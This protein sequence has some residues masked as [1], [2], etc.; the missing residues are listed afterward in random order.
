M[1][2]KTKKKKLKNKID[3]ID[4]NNNAQDS[5]DINK[6]KKKFLKTIDKKEESLI[7]NNNDMKIQNCLKKIKFL[8]HLKLK[9]RYNCT[10]SKYDSYILDY[11]LN[12]LDCHIVSIFKEKM[13]TDYIEEFLRR[14]YNYVECSQRIPK[15]SVYYKNYLNFFCKPIYNSFKFNKIIQNYGEKKAELYYKQNYQGG[16]TNEEGDNG[17]EQSSDDESSN[18]E[19]EYQSKDDGN[20][21]NQQIKEKLD[22]VTVMTTISTG[23]NNTI[24][25]NINNEKIE[26]FSEN[27]ADISNDTTVGE[28]MNDI[29]KEIIKLQ[30]K[31]PKSIKK[32]YKYSY[33]N[34]MNFSLKHQDKSKDNKYRKNLSIENR[35]R[36]NSK[37][38]SKKLLLNKE[39]KDNINKNKIRSNNEK[40]KSQK[41]KSKIIKY[42]IESYKINTNRLKKISRE[43]IEKILKN[44]Y[45][46]NSFNSLYNI[47][48]PYYNFSKDSVSNVRNISSNIKSTENRKSKKAIF[49]GYSEKKI[50]FKSRNHLNSLFKSGI[51][52]MNTTTGQNSNLNLLTTR[53]NKINLTELI[54]S[55]TKTFKTMKLVKTAVHQNTNN[56][57][58][59]KQQF[60]KNKSKISPNNKKMYMPENKMSSMKSLD[61]DLETQHKYIS[62]NNIQ[63]KDKFKKNKNISINLNNNL[64]KINNK[65]K[66]VN[67]NDNKNFNHKITV[68]TN[69]YLNTLKNKTSKV[70]NLSKKRIF[71]SSK[72]IFSIN[73]QKYSYV[74]NNVNPHQLLYNNEECQTFRKNMDYNY[75][76]TSKNNNNIMQIALALLIDNNSP[77][78][79]NIITNSIFNNTSLNNN[80]KII[81]K[82]NIINQK[83]SQN[84]YFNINSPT[85]YNININNQ[86]NI[87]INDKINGK[88][89]NN[90]K[91]K[92][93]KNKLKKNINI[94]TSERERKNN[95]PKKKINQK[96]NTIINNKLTNLYTS[97]NN[98]TNNQIKTRNNND[99]PKIGKT[100]NINSSRNE[101]EIKGYHTKSMSDLEELINHNKKLIALY[102]SMNKINEK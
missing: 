55:G 22:N 38:I 41:I 2:V 76:S 63:K 92:L 8:A 3:V 15:F 19:N 50:K 84:N 96:I 30:N 98:K 54:K 47:N 39:K 80:T 10:P 56:Q 57:L 62:N 100:Q 32:K 89:N 79:K 46:K 14:K 29:K 69:N 11:L 31:K 17:M 75:T 36:L 101:R 20:I 72:E 6:I 26:V 82:Q 59:L 53:R 23:G 37:D 43:K 61:T 42:N 83:D 71:D 77:T 21:F 70:N 48:Y 16:V 64:R 87:N 34:I 74:I 28:I 66:S 35:K 27:K 93:I 86:I 99:H 7:E 97:K 94:N 5:H 78:K 9:K 25:L 91:T 60:G 102:K 13:L 12:N 88:F 24:N 67:T 58:N 90:K 49:S 85:H 68:T 65:N 40:V 52:G 45:T 1:K 44:R 18:K 95:I 4:N 51:R 33:R 81:M 73:N